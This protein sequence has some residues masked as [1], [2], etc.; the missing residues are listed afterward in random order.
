MSEITNVI[1]KY[2]QKQIISIDDGN[3][4]L[5]TIIDYQIQLCN[6]DD[7]YH[8][9]LELAEEFQQN[10]AYDVQYLVVAQHYQAEFWTMD[11]RFYRAV[12]DTLPWVKTIG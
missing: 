5:Q 9:S 3:T 2:I 7:L 10:N 11:M 8:R 6:P 1:R 4:A 12:Q